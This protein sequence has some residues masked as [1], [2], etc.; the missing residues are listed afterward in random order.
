MDTLF[1]ALLI[2]KESPLNFCSKY[3]KSSADKFLTNTSRLEF[4]N[5]MQS[6]KVKL[7]LVVKVMYV[8]NPF[9]IA[10]TFTSDLPISSIIKWLSLP[11]K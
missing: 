8:S 11:F 7:L 4:T 1:F 5:C 2:L 6:I 10:F 9:G 3:L